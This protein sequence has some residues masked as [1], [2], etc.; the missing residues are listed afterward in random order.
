MLTS[1]NSD[2]RWCGDHFREDFDAIFDFICRW[3]FASRLHDKFLVTVIAVQR[4][5]KLSESKSKLSSDFDDDD[6]EYEQ[7]VAAVKLEMF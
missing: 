4:R 3:T 7:E 1:Q 6:L 5:G 2:M